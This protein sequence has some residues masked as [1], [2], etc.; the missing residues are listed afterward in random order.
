MTRAS[1]DN[2]AEGGGNESVIESALKIATK[3]GE[4]TD[5]WAWIDLAF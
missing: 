1:V 4:E 3:K 2:V 5:S